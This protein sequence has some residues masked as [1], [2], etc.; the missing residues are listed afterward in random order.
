MFQMIIWAF[1][2]SIILF[3]ILSLSEKFL[4]LKKVFSQ[5][6]VTSLSAGLLTGLIF[7]KY[8]PHSLEKTSPFMFSM[9]LLCSLMTLLLVD[10]YLTRFL[11]RYLPE[12]S[13]NKASGC[14]HYHQQHH[15]FTQGPFSAISCLLVCSLFDGIRMGTALWIDSST[16][17]IAVIALFAHIL[18]EGLA[19][20]LMA[21]SAD[22]KKRFPV[23]LILCLFFGTGMLLT[24]AG[25][26]DG[27]EQIFLI[28]S[29]ASLFY[30]VFVHLLPAAFEK[31]NQKWF[32][33][34]LLFS[35]V[36]LIHSH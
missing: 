27:F 17:L 34:A 12:W 11:S 8:L 2:I 19:V 32:F 4:I 1:V 20:L 21:Q 26:F 3:S 9:I 36:L 6:H 33:S 13:Q 28:F 23:K 7:F 15:H 22:K 16:S 5:N 35:T 25:S 30:V 31:G 10:S 24:S 29:T 14:G 18:P